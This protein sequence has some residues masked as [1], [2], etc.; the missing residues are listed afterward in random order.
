[1]FRPMLAHDLKGFEIDKL[2][3]PL[4]ASYK[5]DGVRAIVQNGVV[6]SRTLKPIPNKFVQAVFSEFEGMDG[7][8]V[9]GSANSKDVYKKTVSVVMSQNKRDIATTFHVFDSVLFPERAYE[10]REKGINVTG[11]NAVFV[12]QNYVSNINELVEFE[13]Q[14]L[15]LGYEGIMLRDRFS[16]YKFGRSTLKES[17]LIKLKRFTDAEAEVIG[18]QELMIN[19]NESMKN[20]VGYSHRSSMAAGKVQSGM[21]GSLI[22]QT[23]L[24]VVFKVGTG[25]T[26]QDRLDLWGGRDDL[27]GKIVKYKYQEVGKDSRPRFPVFIGFRSEID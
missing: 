5:I 17:A 24:G 14:A 10:S 19:E 1:M 22:C 21:L 23:K 8:L 13:T 20:D 16:P 25:F 11:R 18:V 27:T 9:V 15:S 4:L 6:L 2:L 7:E 26:K 12:R 3:F